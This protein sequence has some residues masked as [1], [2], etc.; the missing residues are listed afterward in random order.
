MKEEFFNKDGERKK[1]KKNSFFAHKNNFNLNKKFDVLQNAQSRRYYST[2]IVSNFV[3][4]LKPKKS[5]CKPTPFQLDEDSPIENDN[6]KSFELDKISSCDEGED[7]GQRS[8]LSSSFIE[9]D[10]EEKNESSNNN[11]E[12]N[13][14]IEPQL[15]NN[16][17]L[18]STKDENVAEYKNLAF[19]KKKSKEKE[20]EEDDDIKSLRK[21]MSKIKSSSMKKAKLSLDLTVYDNLKKNF[22]CNNENNN[23]NNNII[24]LNIYKKTNFSQKKLIINNNL[25]ILDILSN[26]KNNNN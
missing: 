15:K 5:F 24:N 26:K 20:K 11:L 6:D 13:K 7:S 17:G 2:K 18:V 10:K 4:Q 9:S 25:T 14:N 16:N 8:S 19:I 21:E 3:P 12:N 22:F 23:N 1:I